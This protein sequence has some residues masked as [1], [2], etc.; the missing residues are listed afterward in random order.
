AGDGRL[1][2]LVPNPPARQRATRAAA[3]TCGLRYRSIS[4]RSTIAGY[5]GPSAGEPDERLARGVR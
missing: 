1:A 2:S 5:I 3:D 4:S